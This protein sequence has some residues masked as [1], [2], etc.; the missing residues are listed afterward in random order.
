MNDYGASHDFSK[1]KRKP[2][3]L[4]TENKP[5]AFRPRGETRSYIEAIREKL[6]E[7]KM[8]GGLRENWENNSTLINQIIKKAYACYLLEA[9]MKKVKIDVKKE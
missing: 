4:T 9:A 5:I 3:K 1:H 6:N 7:D 8:D 2:R